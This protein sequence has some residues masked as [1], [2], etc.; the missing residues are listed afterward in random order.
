[1]DDASSAVGIV[2]RLPGNPAAV[3]D[4]IAGAVR[5]AFRRWRRT[6]AADDD[7]GARITLHG[8]NRIE[9]Q[10]C[11]APWLEGNPRVALNI[12]IEPAGD[13]SRVTVALGGLSDVLPPVELAGW[14]GSEVIAALVDALSP[15]ELGDW[16]TDRSARRPSGS[17]SRSTYSDPLYHYPN[18]R[19]ILDEL[20]LRPADHVLEIGCGGGALLK[21]VLAS[22]C[23]AAAIDHSAEM[24]ET[25]R[26]NNAD[27]LTSRRLAVCQ[28]SADAVPYR[29]NLFT[30]AIMTGV[31]GFL[32]DPVR[33][34]SE[35]RRVLQPGG[36]FIAL[37]SD[38]AMKGTPAAP[39]PY[40][41]RLHFYEDEELAALGRAAGFTSA[42]VVRR[43]LEEHARSV[44]VPAAHVSLFA[45]ETPFLIAE[46]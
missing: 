43:D 8:S 23:R 4:E 9:L 3:A 25:A 40:A 7:E 11:P 30:A 28:A 6:G 33:A 44:G 39:E 29:E 17:A 34:L 5:Q 36:R 14:L 24:V 41:S 22:G 1:M 38:P 26:D 46:K 32:S 31:L 15:S 12:E 2:I 27:A 37:G 18:F 10:A 45:G 42:R 19:V 21:D 20:R 35:V 13:G 16:V